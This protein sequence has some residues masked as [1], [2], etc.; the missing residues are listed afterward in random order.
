MPTTPPVPAGGKDRAARVVVP[1]DVTVE[2]DDGRE[3]EAMVRDIS[4]T[5]VFLLLDDHLG[6]GTEVTVELRLPAEDALATTRHRAWG[7][8]VRQGNGGYGLIFLDPDPELTDALGAV[9]ARLGVP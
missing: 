5:G 4:T 6:L 8:V 3:V 7:R 1:V 9:C 2:L